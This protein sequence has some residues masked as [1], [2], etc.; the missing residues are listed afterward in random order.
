SLSLPSVSVS[1]SGWVPA[2]ELVGLVAGVTARLSGVAC[3]Q[4]GCR[5]ARPIGAERLRLT[6]GHLSRAI[7]VGAEARSPL[8]GPAYYPWAFA[9]PRPH[10]MLSFER[11]PVRIGLE[12]LF[13]LVIQGL[14]RSDW[15]SPKV[16]ESCVSVSLPAQ[17]NDVF[18]Q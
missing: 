13:H 15:S 16:T 5:A 6:A 2:V 10:A 14:T 4:G 3:D 17:L 8:V 9:S 18:A 12:R 7:S 11:K 1:L